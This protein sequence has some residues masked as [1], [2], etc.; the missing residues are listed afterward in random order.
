MKTRIFAC[1]LVLSSS[2]FASEEKYHTPSNSLICNVYTRELG[3]EVR[4]TAPLTEQG[5]VIEEFVG[6]RYQIKIVAKRYHCFVSR[7]VKDIVTGEH[8]SDAGNC[9]LY[10]YLPIQDVNREYTYYHICETTK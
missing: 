10:D 1:I 4:F 8:I 7:E 5:A 3:K 9:A 2:A 6:G